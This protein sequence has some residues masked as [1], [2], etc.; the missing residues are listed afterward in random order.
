[1]LAIVS[2]SE[3]IVDIGKFWLNGKEMVLWKLLPRKLSGIYGLV[4]LS[5]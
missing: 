1:M 2:V 4:W 5:G 3:N